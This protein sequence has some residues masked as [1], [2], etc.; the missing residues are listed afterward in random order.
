MTAAAPTIDYSADSYARAL[1]PGASVHQDDARIFERAGH[2]YDPLLRLSEAR[3][4]D[5]F[6]GDFACTG[7]LASGAT[8]E[9]RVT[10]AGPSALRLRLGFPGAA[11]RSDSPLLLPQS[12]RR[13]IVTTETPTHWELR[14][15]GAILRLG[16]AAFSLDLV[17]EDGTRVFQVDTGKLAGSHVGGP[18]GFRTPQGG[19]PQAYLGWLI[20]NRDRYYG[21]GEKWNAVE[22]T[23]TRSTVWCSDT[24][25]SNSND[26]AYK[27]LPLIHCDQGWSLLLHSTFRSHWEIGTFS[28]INGSVLV[29]DERLDLL[30]WTGRDLKEQIA[31]YATLTGRPAMPPKWAFGTWMSRCQYMNQGEAEEAMRGLRERGIPADVIHLDPMWMPRH[32]YFKIG[33]DAC[34]FDWNDQGFPD[35]RALFARWRD[36]GFHTCLWVN[37]YLPETHPIYTEATNSGYLLRDATGGIA[38]LSHGEAVGMVDFTNPAAKAW[39][40]GKLEG[41]LRDGAAVIK[42]DY[43]DRVP[44][45]AVAHNGMRGSELH[46]LYLHLYCE[47]AYQAA[48]AVRG[49]GIVW[50]RAGFIGTQRYPGTWAGDTQTTWEAFRCCLRGGLSAGFGAEGLWS[51]DIGGFC[52]PMPSPELFIRWMQLGFLSPFTRFHGNGLREP[53][54]YGDTATAVAQHYGQLRYRLIPYLLAAAEEACARGLPLQRALALE[55]QGQPGVERIDDQLLLGPDLLLNPVQEA[56]ARTRTA[57]LPEALW[58]PLDGGAPLAGGRFAVLPAPLERM[59]VLVRG[60]ALIPSYPEAQQHLKQPVPERLQLTAYASDRCRLR[61]LA[62]DDGA[63]RVEAAH[64]SSDAG[65]TVT[66]RCARAVTVRIIGGDADA[67]D[68]PPGGGEVRY[69]RDAAAGCS[70]RHG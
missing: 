7:H 47:T 16:R 39:W 42:P 63:G 44:E 51:H 6:G 32:Y 1:K 41:C 56:G 36:D 9:L 28:Y 57:W 22:K 34:D 12:Q 67:I 55:F 62:F 68:L 59:P 70:T 27:P 5:C 29:E 4:G 14:V 21:L 61:T 8:V 40:Q 13:V 2:A 33:V 24:C 64:A 20:G 50:R 65:G 18:I 35:H 19:T 25:G 17:R 10:A 58:H 49:E 43:G 38:R 37:P 30:L 3:F 48:V 23:G 31:T 46:N 54:H 45:S 52:G 66:V 53:W 11:W 26:M 15:E 60:G 69:R